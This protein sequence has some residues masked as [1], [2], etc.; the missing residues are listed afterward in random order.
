MSAAPRN[1]RSAR[2]LCLDLA[3]ASGGLW[4]VLRAAGPYQLARHKAARAR[5]PVS[6]RGSRGGGC[7]SGIPRCGA[8]A[9]L[10]YHTVTARLLRRTAPASIVRVLPLPPPPSP[11]PACPPR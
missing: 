6:P 7:G 9:V 4:P 3:R 10:R 1:A 11:S 5:E 8:I 2:L